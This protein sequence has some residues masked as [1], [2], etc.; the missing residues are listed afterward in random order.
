MKDK[1]KHVKPTTGGESSEPTSQS[2]SESHSVSQP[3]TQSSSNSTRIPS[4]D[5]VS[6]NTSSGLVMTLL[7]LVRQ[8]TVLYIDTIGAVGD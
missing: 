7:F 5:N 3:N 1:R 2:Q 8:P 6:T 4:I